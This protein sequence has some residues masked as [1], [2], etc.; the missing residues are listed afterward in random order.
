MKIENVEGIIWDLDGTLLNSFGIF[1]QIISDIVHETGH[2]MP[3]HEN[4]LQNY[5]GSLEETVQRLLGINSADEL[6]SLITAF[7]KKQEYH[8]AGDLDAHLFKDATMLAQKAAK[9]GIHQL[10]VTNRAHKGRGSASP[11]F[12]IASTV[13]ADCINEV[14]PGDEVE[15]RKPDIRSTGNWMEEHYLKPE[16]TVVIGD[17]I[18]DA[19]LALNIGSRAILIKRIGEIPHIE[20]LDNKNGNE[21]VIVDNLADIEFA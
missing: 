12:I 16:N 2:K 15:Y 21:V 6:D 7:L 19:Q 17:Q 1:E 20:S 10:L 18:V 3:S 5:H 11:K 8:Y 13:L 4:M 14:K 9:Q